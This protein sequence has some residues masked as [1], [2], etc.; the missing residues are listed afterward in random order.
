[1]TLLIRAEDSTCIKIVDYVAVGRQF[2]KACPVDQNRYCYDHLAKIAKD[3]EDAP[4]LGQQKGPTPRELFWA[5]VAQ[6][7]SSAVEGP[8]S[9]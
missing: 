3:F 2:G 5:G 8:A 1:M 7:I 4:L 9:P 6:S